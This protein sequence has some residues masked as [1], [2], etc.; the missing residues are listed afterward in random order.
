M[1]NQCIQHLLEEHR[2]AERVLDAF[3]AFLDRLEASPAWTAAHEEAFAPIR[4][5][6][7]G[8]W[9]AHRQK[10]EQLFF[11]VLEAFLPRD[12]GPL[13]VLRGEF[14]E[15]AGETDR[16]LLSANLIAHGGVHAKTLHAFQRAA[17]ALCQL[18]RDHIYKVDRV[19][20]PMVARQLPPEKDG[21][22][23]AAMH[24]AGRSRAT[25][26]FRMRSS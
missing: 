15:I 7:A 3:D 20:F 6:L 23:L 18:L 17:R 16:V 13:E 21:E 10:E 24:A 8:H 19:L 1:A 22:L 25:A 11:P 14:E 4:A 9:P 5:F 2:A 12:A 26:G